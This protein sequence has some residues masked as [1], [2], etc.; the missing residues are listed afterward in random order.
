MFDGNETRFDYVVVGSGAGGG[1]V[2]ANLAAAGFKVALV[3]AGS[4]HKSLNYAVPGFHGQATQDAAMRWDFFV[5]HYADRAQQVRDSKYRAD[6]QGQAVDGVLYPRSATLGGCTAHNAM[7]TV[8]P[9][10]SDWRGLSEIA[11]A[12]DPS[13]G[14]WEP[15]AMRRYFERIERCGYIADDDPELRA[16]RHGDSG[17][18]G[19]SMADPRLLLGDKGLLKQVI[20]AF[21]QTL[22]DLFP[23]SPDQALDKLERVLRLAPILK[24]LLDPETL[25]DPEATVRSLWKLLD[26]NRDGVGRQEGVYLIPLAVAQGLRNGSRERILQ[27]EMRT[28]DLLHIR[29]DAMVT[30]IV[31]EGGRAVGVEYLPGGRRYEASPAPGGGRPAG[32]APVTL[33]ADR[34][35]IL[36][37][38]TFNTP[39]VLML[40]G[41]GPRADLERLGIPVVL[42]R[43]A[44]GRYLQDR[45][46]VAVVSKF[47]KPFPLLDGLTFRPPG[48]GEEP[49][50]ALKQWEESRSGLYATNG[51]VLAVIRRSDPDLEDPDLFIFGLP[52]TFKG[53]YPGYADAI[54]GDHDAF[55]WAIL[56]GHTENQGGRVTLKSARP[57]ERPEIQFHYFQEGTDKA[58]ADLEA[59]VQ[60]V[61]FVR[62]FNDKLGQPCRLVVRRNDRSFGTAELDI[63]SDDQVRQWVKDEAWGHH[64]CGTC[65]IGPKEDVTE[66]VLDSDFRVKGLDG[67]RV[68][69]ASVFPR[70]PGLFIV[71]AIYMV[72]EKASEVILR[73]AGRALPDVDW[74]PLPD[75]T[76]Q[77]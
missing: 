4:Y 23:R 18:L 62:E 28:P 16:G 60:G 35:V 59:V 67:L 26:P 24:E 38:G 42:D 46:E 33:H 50:P 10:D 58:G 34:E 55:T 64:A 37:G 76:W 1:P 43:P 21:N 9:H 5:R 31:I 53:Y 15:A 11:R 54:A 39:Q 75:S 7:I 68:V 57:E 13:D 69:D 74:A 65:R 72:A 56:K 52:A 36:A 8:Y 2:A 48:P 6:Y 70:I 29:T 12:D 45:Y 71:S 32:G 3:E 30:R 41:I 17:Y 49:D 47:P 20:G 19:T 73:D 61:R 44:V 27:Q 25:H 51:A 14:S 40:S 63:N 66:S 77:P 22:I